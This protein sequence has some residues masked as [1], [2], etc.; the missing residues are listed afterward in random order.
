MLIIALKFKTQLFA[1]SVGFDGGGGEVVSI[2]GSGGH[3]NFFQ[4]LEDG[5]KLAKVSVLCS[6]HMKRM[7]TLEAIKKTLYD[8]TQFTYALLGLHQAHL[9]VGHRLQIKRRNMRLKSY[10]FLSSRLLM[11]FGLACRLLPVF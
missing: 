8:I 11:I 2:T 9:Y 5:E 1:V 6:F 10:I 3:V 4:N 7:K